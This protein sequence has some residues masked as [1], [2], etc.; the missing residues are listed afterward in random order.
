MGTTPLFDFQRPGVE[1]FPY[2]RPS[3]FPPSFDG[4]PWAY[5]FG[6]FGDVVASALALTLLATI[7]LESRR[8][9]QA[10]RLLGNYVDNPREPLWSPLFI[11]RASTV[12]MLTFI[13]MRC[14]PD[15]LW[16]LAWG[17]V[18]EPTIRAMLALDL[19]A[20]GV[21]L[22]PFFISIICW[23]WGRQVIP[24]RLM[25]GDGLKGARRPSWSTIWKNGRIVLVVLLIAVGVT[26][27]KASA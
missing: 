6:L 13:V 22:V 23:A 24:H 17:E 18:S 27:G 7:V 21:A 2:A 10:D 20:D 5:G 3:P 9:R 25:N 19:W 11:Y 1:F 14:L 4:N 15:A 12:S 16:M 8:K 26:I